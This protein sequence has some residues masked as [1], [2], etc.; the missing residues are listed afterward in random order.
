M[1]EDHLYMIDI[2]IKKYLGKG[3]DYDDLYQAAA[4]G[5]VE[6]SNRFDPDKGFE[7]KTFATATILGEIK[8]YFRDTQWDLKVPRTKK[9]RAMKVRE[10]E[11]RFTT[12]TGRAPTAGELAEETCYTEEQVIEALESA[13]AYAAYSLDSDPGEAADRSGTVS[14]DSIGNSLYR[15]LGQED[16]GFERVEINEIIRK[17]LGSMTDTN[18]YIFRQRFIEEKTQTEIARTLGVSQMTISRAEKSIVDRFR[19]ELDKA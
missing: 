14:G 15:A 11:E 16:K 7:F 2:L 4:V 1:V 10:A 12:R 13:N 9:E 8:K 18:R 6:A 5:L 3:V 17:V 19:A